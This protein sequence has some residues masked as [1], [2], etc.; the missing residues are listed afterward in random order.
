MAN[1][2]FGGVGY[3]DVYSCVGIF[4]GEPD[5]HF[6]PWRKRPQHDLISG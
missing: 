3:S 5:F 4:H 1:A 6:P 2:L